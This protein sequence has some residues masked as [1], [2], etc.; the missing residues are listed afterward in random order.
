MENRAVY[1]PTTEAAP[2]A[3]RGGLTACFTL[4]RLTRPQRV[5]KGLQLVR[6]RAAE[7]ERALGRGSGQ[8]QGG[9]LGAGEDASRLLLARPRR[10]GSS[11]FHTAVPSLPSGEGGVAVRL[12]P[13]A[14]PQFLSPIHRILLCLL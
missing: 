7:D 13:V 9:D 4:G 12:L 8:G 14:R 11:R 10:S 5:L 6:S 1:G 3:G 2:G